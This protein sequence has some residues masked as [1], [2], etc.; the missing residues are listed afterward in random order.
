MSDET[1]GSVKNR[2]R[3][4]LN[5]QATVVVMVALYCVVRKARATGTGRASKP[6]E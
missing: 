2:S 5:V 4:N 1:L 3:T 6:V